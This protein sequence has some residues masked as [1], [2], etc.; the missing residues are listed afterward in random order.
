MS[1]STAAAGNRLGVAGIYADPS[2]A[3]AGSAVVREGKLRA[4]A[5]EAGRAHRRARTLADVAEAGF[6][7]IKGR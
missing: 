1:H 3:A 4:P 2:G 6:P 7:D 5:V